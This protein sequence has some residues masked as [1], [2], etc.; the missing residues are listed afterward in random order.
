[1]P[2]EGGG[3][4]KWWNLV[5]THGALPNHSLPRIQ[6]HTRPAAFFGVQFNKKERLCHLEQ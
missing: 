1:M 2:L 3:A 5:P 4:N 6:I